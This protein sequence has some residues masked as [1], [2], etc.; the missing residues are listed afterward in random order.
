[1]ATPAPGSPPVGCATRTIPPTA[2]IKNCSSPDCGLTH[3]RLGA[4]LTGGGVGAAE[5]RGAQDRPA[6]RPFARSL[7]ERSRGNTSRSPDE[8]EHHVQHVG[9]G[10]PR[11]R[12][13]TGFAGGGR[14]V[15]RSVQWSASADSTVTGRSAGI[16][17]VTAPRKPMSTRGVMGSVVAGRPN[18]DA[19]P[20]PVPSP[21][22]GP[23]WPGGQWSATGGSRPG[24]DARPPRQ[25]EPPR[26][27]WWTRSRIGT[28]RTIGGRRRSPP[29]HTHP[30]QGVGR[31]H[32][33]RSCRDRA[34]SGGG[35][36][37][38]ARGLP[39][40]ALSCN[41]SCPVPG[42]LPVP[43]IGHVQLRRP[44]PHPASCPRAA[45][46]V[47]AR[48]PTW[49]PASSRT[50]Q[51]KAS[52]GQ[53]GLDQRGVHRPG[54]RSLTGGGHGG[55]PTSTSGRRSRC[56]RVEEG[57]QGVGGVGSNRASCL[58]ASRG[59]SLVPSGSCR[60]AGRCGL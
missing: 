21:P 44:R 47:S 25:Q 24:R 53:R 19:F 32:Q 51:L 15:D 2:G 50:R 48:R 33:P 35:P 49:P 29:Q 36:T 6:G 59:R 7:R 23:A 54:P 17:V 41:T 46:Q 5:C 38:A 20:R 11:Q 43:V 60:R 34:T 13:V 26:F 28:S 1:M 14:P 57:E 31:S 8:D 37:R 42:L 9:D 55:P 3:R 58:V 40:L 52:R 18:A 39:C 4:R 56:T 22:P 30:A 12:D 10:R 45:Y 27:S 16:R